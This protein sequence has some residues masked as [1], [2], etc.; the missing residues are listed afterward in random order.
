MAT[1]SAT[2]CAASLTKPGRDD[3]LAK[4]ANWISEWQAISPFLGLT[5]AEEKEILEST[6]SV[7]VRRMSMLRKW[8]QKLGLEATY[9]RLCRVF[10]DCERVDLVDKIKQLPFTVEGNRHL[11][12]YTVQ[13]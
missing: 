8:K 11:S 4:I 10:K 6:H 5:D 7:Q 2:A 3:H 9:K 12:H 1:N 13:H